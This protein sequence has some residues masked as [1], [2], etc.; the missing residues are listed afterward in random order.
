[1][2]WKKFHLTFV[3]HNEQIEKEA[4]NREGNYSSE[5]QKKAVLKLQT[6]RLLYLFHMASNR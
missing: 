4:S 1:L 3:F 6:K 2:K 5:A